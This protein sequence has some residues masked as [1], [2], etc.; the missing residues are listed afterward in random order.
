MSRTFIRQDTQIRNSDVY[1]DTTPPTEAAYETNPTHIETDLNNLRSQIQ[2]F[3]N[4]D[5]AG[6]P[7]GNWYDDLTA[8]STLE[9]GTQRGIDSLNDALHLIEK[10][11]VLKC[12]FGLNS[13][14]IASAGDTFDVL[15]TGELPG[16]TTAAVGAVT[17][18]GTVVAAHTGTFGTH[19]LDEVGGSTAISP[20]NLVEIVDAATRDPILDAGDKIYGL[21]Q[22]EDATDGHTITDATTTRVQLSFVKLNGTGDDLIA[23]ASGAMDGV[24]YDYCYNER[25]RLEDLNEADFLGGASIDV[26][27]GATVTRQ[28]AYDNQGTTPVD[29]TTNAVLDLEGAGLSWTVRDDLEAALF[30]IVE[31]SAGGTSQ[32]NIHS[33]VDEFDVD[34]AVNDFANGVTMDSAGTA[35]NVGVTTAQIDAAASLTLASTGG[36]SDLFLSAGNEMYFDDTNQTGSTWAQ[37]AGIKLSE[38]TAEWD[39]FETAFGGEVSLLNAIVQAK[40][41]SSRTKGVAVVTSTA[42][43]GV[44]VTGGTN[45]DASLPDYSGVTSFEDEVDVYLNGVLLRGDNST[46]GANDHDVYPGDTPANGDLKFEFTVK[47]TGSSP[48]VITM[49]VYG[50]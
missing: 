37:T 19:A 3:L 14:S 33:G 13:I 11:R 32:V 39:N 26:P 27:A 22:S 9:A 28:V 25:V 2:N 42:N 30:S 50:S 47:A 29:L 12:I 24:S 18:L 43:A 21:L 48:D 8:P 40:N 16:N 34:A 23:I 10:K 46:T 35:I 45:L 6:F 7:A 41:S 36:A 31:G 20:K 4:R 5:G 49:I 15:G 1:D 44:N 38:T 17:T